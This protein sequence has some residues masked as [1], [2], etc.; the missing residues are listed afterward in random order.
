MHEMVWMIDGISPLR[1]KGGTRNGKMISGMK[2]QMHG[3][4]GPKL[5][6]NDFKNVN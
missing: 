4:E 3:F 5:S 2:M 1:S 6:D